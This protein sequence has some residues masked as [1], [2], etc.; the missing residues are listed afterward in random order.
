MNEQTR[1]WW[2]RV[3]RFK[4]AGKR[5]GCNQGLSKNQ[6]NELIVRANGACECCHKQVSK[7]GI[8]HNH[9]TGKVRGILCNSCNLGIGYLEKPNFVEIATIYLSKFD[10]VMLT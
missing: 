8:D 7:F 9:I 3:G 4:Y 6:V 5:R 2:A 1:N 10:S